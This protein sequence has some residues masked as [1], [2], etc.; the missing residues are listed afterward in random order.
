MER[1][2]GPPERRWSTAD[3]GEGVAELGERSLE[4]LDEGV[5][6]VCGQDVVVDVEP[7]QADIMD[8]ESDTEAGDAHVEPGNSLR[9]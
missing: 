1:A 2:R 3:H 4:V 8:D 5:R 6:S 7:L 9:A